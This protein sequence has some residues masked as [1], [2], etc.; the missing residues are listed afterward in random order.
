MDSVLILD[1]NQEWLLN[2][3]RKLY[4]WSVKHSGESYGDLWNWII[5]PRNLRI[6]FGRVASNKGGK[7]PGIDGVTV[8][9]IVKQVG[10][11]KYVSH[12]REQLCTGQYKPQAVRRRWI[13]KTGKPGQLRGLGIPTIDDRVVQSAIKQI[14]E[15]IFEA[16]FSHVSHGFRPGRAVRDAIENIRMMMRMKKLDS[17][18]LRPKPKFEWVIEG[19]IQ[20]CFDQIDHHSLMKRIRNRISDKKLNRLI[21]QF[22]KA[23]I[24]EEKSYIRS[25]AG[26]PQG[27]IISPLLANIALGVIEERY[28]RWVYPVNA[29]HRNEGVTRA[30][31]AKNRTRDHQNDLPV[32]YP[33]R[34]ADDFVILCTGSREQAEKERQELGNFLKQELNLTLSPEKTR[35]TQVTEGFE[36]LGHRIQ[37]RKNPNIGWIPIT[38]IPS[39]AKA[40]FRQ[41][42]K[43]V[44]S[45]KTSGK[46]SLRWLLKKCNPIIQGWA[47]FYQHTTGAWKPFKTMDGFLFWRIEGWLKKKHPKANIHSIYDKYYRRSGS[48]QTL[49]WIEKGISCARM[50]DTPRGAWNPRKRKIPHFMFQAGEP[51]T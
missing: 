40:R 19:D 30:L 50:L 18:G 8:I 44:T 1:K 13:P 28:K 36:F 9:T 37:L 41:K 24:M 21:L 22:L 27:G 49:G 45:R 42:I 31:A 43:V 3:Q 39:K 20:S 10:E 32:R 11:E 38:S 29:G 46:K 7:T 17:H 5:D 15:P 14:I 6:A 47:T 33:I 16:N 12:L 51:G 34:Y 48:R 35:I 4:Q 26:T 25:T 23:G 2:I